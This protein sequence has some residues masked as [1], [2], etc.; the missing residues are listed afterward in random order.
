MTL[1]DSLKRYAIQFLGTGVDWLRAELRARAIPV[2]ITEACLRELLSDADAAARRRTSGSDAGADY[3]ALLRQELQIRA[4]FLRTWT[5]S[6]DGIDLRDVSYDHLVSVARRY[7]LPRSW[8]L[9][10]PT[11]SAC[12]RPTPTY[13][14]WART[15]T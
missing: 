3:V 2:R 5:L 15:T 7:A 4:D 8:R 13:L 1:A 14:Y 12:S 11:A 10:E 6:D 9:S